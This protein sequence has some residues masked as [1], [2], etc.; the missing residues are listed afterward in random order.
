L[1][2]IA[3]YLNSDFVAY[4]QF[5]T[6]T[7]AGIQ[8]S[9]NTLKALRL[10]P[11]PFD[12]DSNL[13]PWESLYD[14]IATQCAGRDDF[15]IP[16]LVEA[17]NDLTAESLKLSSRA[18]AAVHDLVHV[19]FG[20]IQGKTDVSAIGQPV[21]GEF[22][23]YAT[24]LREELDGFVAASSDKRHQVDVMFGGGTGLVSVNIVSA[25]SVEQP[26]RVIEAR[27]TD[28]SELEKTRLLLSERRDQWLYFDRNLRVYDGPRTYILKPL[29][30]LH[31]TQTQ[32]IRDAGEIIADSLRAQSSEKMEIAH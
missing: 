22:V 3:L 32:A 8:K 17:V 18:R 27:S 28:A 6:T 25:G 31:W 16:S 21:G 10:L 5:L 24:M 1:K 15:D 19:R 2:A 30:H 11:L 23:S 9:R 4:H 12:A 29:Q 26:V 7:E 13:E 14:R 20:L